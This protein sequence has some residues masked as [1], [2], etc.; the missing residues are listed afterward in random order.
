MM[1]NSLVRYIDKSAERLPDKTAVR[2]DEKA[3]TYSE[4]RTTARKAASYLVKLN[5]ECERRPVMVFLPRCVDAI[6]CFMGALYSGNPYVPVNYALPD[7]R[8]S[9]TLSNLSP[10]CV[11]T[12]NDG[13]EKINA[14]APL[15]KSVTFS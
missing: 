12:D 4:L 6:V 15:V 5:S 3:Y 8:L 9:S 14:I 2:D 7:V 11:I 13:R 1:L 10:L